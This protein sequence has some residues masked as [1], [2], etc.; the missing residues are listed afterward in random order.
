M[1]RKLIQPLAAAIAI[2]LT[3]SAFAAPSFDVADI[4]KAISPCADFNGFV[5]AK[6]VAK[7]PIP[8]D[9]TRW[10]AFDQLREHSLET[11]HG[12]VEKA[13]KNTQAKAGSIEQKVGWFYHSGMDE[14]AVEKAGHA[15]L[16]AELAKIDALKG[17]PDIVAYVTASAAQGRAD[18]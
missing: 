8:A 7:N 10:G 12:I 17:A 1:S 6:W 3:G 5:N 14:A 11:Q 18:L 15:P 4:D 9:R 13:A 2:A 16:K